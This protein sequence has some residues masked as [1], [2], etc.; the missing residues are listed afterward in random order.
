MGFRFV[1][2][3]MTLPYLERS[4]AHGINGN[5]KVICY[6]RNV[7]IVLV[8]DAN[9]RQIQRKVKSDVFIDHSID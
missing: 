2:K 8:I 1:Q 7:R 9:L 5:Q 3:S 4:N 6:G